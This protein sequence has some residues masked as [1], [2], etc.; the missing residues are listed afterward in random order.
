MNI[1]G[2]NFPQLGGLIKSLAT[3]TLVFQTQDNLVEN[4]FRYHLS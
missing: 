4:N 2:R 3:I 1:I